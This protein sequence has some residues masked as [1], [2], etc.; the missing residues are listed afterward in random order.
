MA[1][2]VY[3]ALEGNCAYNSKVT[4]CLKEFQVVS[5]CPICQRKPFIST[6]FIG[7]LTVIVRI[8]QKRT[9]KKIVWIPTDGGLQFPLGRNHVEL[10]KQVH[11]RRILQGSSLIRTCELKLE[12]F[13][14]ETSDSVTNRERNKFAFDHVKA[15]CC[16]KEMLAA[17]RQQLQAWDSRATRKSACYVPSCKRCVKRTS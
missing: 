1:I 16:M 7:I 2:L 5:L 15:S 4:S 14:L 10:C 11:Q 17:H 12:L 6:V 3:E 13:N 8:Y 9:R